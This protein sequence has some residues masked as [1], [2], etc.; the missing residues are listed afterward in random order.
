[1]PV[2]GEAKRWDICCCAVFGVCTAE[3]SVSVRASAGKAML[4]ETLH[5]LV[6]MLI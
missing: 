1:M 4:Q 6:H 3:V 5:C 2:L